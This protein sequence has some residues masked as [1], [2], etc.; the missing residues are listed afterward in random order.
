VLSI[1]RG[2]NI[3]RESLYRGSDGIT[4]SLWLLLCHRAEM[5]LAIE[6]KRQDIYR[7]KAPQQ[8][9][10]LLFSPYFVDRKLV[11]RLTLTVSFIVVSIE[12]GVDPTRPPDLL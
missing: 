3:I 4:V 2:T 5:R 11:V 1:R 9:F 8:T 12:I 7:W 6:P 10:C